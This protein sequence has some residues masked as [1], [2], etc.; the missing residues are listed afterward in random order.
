ML[1]E[2]IFWGNSVPDPEAAIYYLNEHLT[3]KNK[4]IRVLL[5]RQCLQHFTGKCPETC[6]IFRKFD[7]KSYIFNKC[8]KP[9]C[10]IFIERRCC[11]FFFKAIFSSLKLKASEIHPAY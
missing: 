2:S 4:I 6:M 11:C 8:D 5:K 1:P 9:L 10:N 3:V 7:A